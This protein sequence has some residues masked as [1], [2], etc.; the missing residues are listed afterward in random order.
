MLWV[1]YQSAEKQSVRLAMDRKALVNYFAPYIERAGFKVPQ[2]LKE[3]SVDQ[4]TTVLTVF[5]K[6]PYFL[7]GM[8]RSELENLLE[9]LQDE[10]DNLE[11]NEP[12]E[13]DAVSHN[14]WEDAIDEIEDKIQA[15]ENRLEGNH[16][17]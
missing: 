14:W 11:C 9:H 17:G 16:H 12:D 6:D 13:E 4:L 1:S 8:S 3:L 2:D 7:D 5:V 10:L 15:I